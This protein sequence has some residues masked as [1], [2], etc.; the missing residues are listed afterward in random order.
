MTVSAVPRIAGPYAGNDVATS[1]PFAFTVVAAA[2]VQVQ[3]VTSLGIESTL[4]QDADYSVTVNEDQ[5][6]SPGGSITYPLSG[7]PLTIGET[8]TVLG[9]TEYS[10]ET[11]LPNGGAFNAL[12]VERALDRLTILAQQ[13]LER[14]GRT[15]GF[16]SSSSSTASLIVPDPEAST[17]LG[18]NAAA[19]ALQNY[20]LSEATPVAAY[21]AEEH[22]ATASQTVFTLA[23]AY[24]PSANTLSV[25]VNGLLMSVTSDYIETAATT[26]T[27]N[28]GL[29]VGDEVTFQV[30]RTNI[31]TSGDAANTSYSPAGTGAVATTVQSALRQWVSVLDFA[32]DGVSGAAVDPTGVLDSTDGINAAIAYAKATERIKCVIFPTGIYKTS[33]S[34]VIGGNFDAGIE[35]WGHQA[36]I[37]CSGNVPIIDINCRVPD[38]PPQVRMNCYVHGFTLVGP[39]IGS[40]SSVG[41]KAQRG[42]GVK[43]ENCSL[44]EVYRGVWGFG[45]LIS[46]YSD[47][48]IYST[49]YPL[50]FE[51]DDIE[52]APNDL[53]FTR[54]KAFDNERSCRMVDFPNGA[55]TFISCELEGNNLSGGLADGVKNAE[56]SNAGKVTMLGCHMEANP[57]QYNLYFDGG[58]NAHLSLNGCEIIPGDS[59]AN[60]VYMANVTGSPSLFV[61]GSRVTNN[62]V[63][64][65]IVMSTGS[66]GYFIGTQ[67]GQVSGDLG[68]VVF[69]TAGVVGVGRDGSVVDGAGVAFP[70]TQV[71]ST[72]ANTLDDYAEGTFSPTVIG[73]S[74]A[75]SATYANQNGRYTKIGRQVFVEIYLNWSAGTGT[76]DLAIASLPFTVYGGIAYFPSA[77][78][79]RTNNIAW[80]AGSIPCANFS[81]GTTQI[82]FFQQPSGGGAVAAIPY[83]AAGYIM[84]SG[85]YTV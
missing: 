56:F 20:P 58:N 82:L 50:D 77:T 28:S 59:C 15:L 69:M 74:T 36:T 53:H 79:G 40:T 38:T 27:F 42:A 2:D 60:V 4:V 18:W 62:V 84:V 63:G 16:S 32:A 7:S 21:V 39:G 6:A 41:I 19:N 78:I 85:T 43:V 3:R 1:F 23:N 44:T 12:V 76:G 65:R 64:G 14:I 71:P 24:T 9:N 73:L 81:P 68:K 31:A 34:I 33:D 26:V 55:M 54:I 8:L 51:P 45:N 66:K 5:T 80:T 61:S 30:W 49:F 67:A 48:N 35:V 70:P 72:N 29:T 52:F 22:T 25:Y 10:Q 17:V 11:Q 47:L 75:G 46:H 83:D 13:L 57:G 37:N